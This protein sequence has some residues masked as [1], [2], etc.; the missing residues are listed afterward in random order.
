[1]NRFKK[2]WRGVEM[3]VENEHGVN[4]LVQH[5][6]TRDEYRLFAA[7]KAGLY[8]AN[9]VDVGAHAGAFTAQVK[10]LW[11]GAQVVAVEPMPETLEL[12]RLNVGSK[13]GVTI[14]P[15]AVRNDRNGTV[16]MTPHNWGAISVGAESLAEK[17]AL[18][19]GTVETCSLE[20][21]FALAA[22]GV[23]DY[24]KM[25]CEHSEIDILR[26]PVLELL[27]RV[28]FFGAEIHSDASLLAYMAATERFEMRAIIGCDFF[29]GPR[30]DL[31][32][33]LDPVNDV[34]SF[35]L[36]G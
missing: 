21:V 22:P 23:I 25:D 32:A 12:L 2:W 8:L 16:W 36:H 1:M 6:I 3:T 30:G 17:G 19:G 14:V 31:H 4:T 27:E 29:A 34:P 9:V 10:H 18:P 24:L 11:P 7:H 15:K 13:P 28:R 26:G 33:L 5:V 35:E 20:E